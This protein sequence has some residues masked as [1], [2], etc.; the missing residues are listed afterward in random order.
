MSRAL[1]NRGWRILSGSFHHLLDA[2]ARRK[3]GA[4]RVGAEF[5]GDL[6]DDRVARIAGGVDGWPKPTMTSC[7][8]RRSLDVGLGLV[9]V[10]IAGWMSCATS[11]APPCFG[12]RSSADRAGHARI[13]PGARAGDD[14]RGERRALNS[15]SA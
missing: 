7:R 1:T 8:A 2:L 12:P 14:A 15:C 3:R 9:G 11:L 10:A 4:A 13:K 6:L 5:A